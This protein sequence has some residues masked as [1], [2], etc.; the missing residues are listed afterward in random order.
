MRDLLKKVVRDPKSSDYLFNL[1]I[2]LEYM[3]T[4]KG[5]VYVNISLGTLSVLNSCV[6][7]HSPWL[8]QLSKVPTTKDI[9]IAKNRLSLSANAPKKW[10]NLFFSI[11][12]TPDLSL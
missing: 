2:V 7:R 4:K 6:T 11:A 12:I 1:V 5:T 10:A 3:E 9:L 8:I